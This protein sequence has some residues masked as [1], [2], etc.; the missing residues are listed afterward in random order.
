MQSDTFYKVALGLVPKVGAITA[1]KLITHLGSAEAVFQSKPAELEKISGIGPQ[2]A[3]QISDAQV[4]KR[5][6]TECALAEQHGIRILSA[7]DAAYPDR[8][9]HNRDSP[10]VL[11]VKGQTQLNGSRMV[12]IVGT[13]KPSPQGIYNC[14]RIVEELLDYQVTII[15]GMAYGIDIC[16][17]RAAVRHQLPTW[18]VMA[19]GHQYLYPA[20]HKKVARQMLEQE[21][22]LLSEYSFSTRAEKEFFPMRNR[23]VAGLC[24]ALI[25]VETAKRGGSMITAQLANQYYRDVFAFPGRVNDPLSKG[26]NLLIKGHQAALLES[27]ADLAYVLRWKTTKNQQGLQRELFLELSEEEKIIVDLLRQRDQLG[28]DDLAMKLDTTGSQI[29][30]IL[31]N[32]EFKNLIKSLPG[33]RYTLI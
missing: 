30:T 31:L 10:L 2:L 15:S 1:K 3:Q 33:S 5:A 32:L 26:C 13:R 27:A 11:Y 22:S 24:D 20:A 19:H 6:E 8:L 17:H 7:E 18:G 28:I 14:E 25:V 12:A 23:I 16:A 4:L 29:S 21:G 9:R